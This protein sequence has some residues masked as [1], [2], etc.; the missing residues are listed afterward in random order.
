MLQIQ[1][2]NTHL[3][4]TLRSRFVNIKL[5]ELLLTFPK[6][7]I[8]WSD[9]NR[10]CGHNCW[11]FTS[12][13]SINQWPVKLKY[14]DKLFSFFAVGL[15]FQWKPKLFLTKWCLDFSHRL[16]GV[17]KVSLLVLAP[18][19]HAQNRLPPSERDF[20]WPGTNFRTW[21]EQ[22]SRKRIFFKLTNGLNMSKTKA[23]KS[24]KFLQ[25]KL[26]NSFWVT[27]CRW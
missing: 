21:V 3:E 6:I 9:R 8:A 2:K 18:A 24:A 23:L 17:G 10:P 22:P 4:S 16:S 7:R 26:F 20:R 25:V 15:H 11:R 19:V 27:F 14:D 13:R 12:R 1:L 5:L